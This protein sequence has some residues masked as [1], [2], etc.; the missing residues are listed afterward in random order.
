MKAAGWTVADIDA[1]EKEHHNLVQAAAAKLALQG[2]L[3][4]CKDGVLNKSYHD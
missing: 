2:A 1:M 3:D 4:A